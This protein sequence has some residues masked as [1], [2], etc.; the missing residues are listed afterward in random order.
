[1]VRFSPQ[2]IHGQTERTPRDQIAQPS[3]QKNPPKVHNLGRA[4]ALVVEKVAVGPPSERAD[5]SFV[6]RMANDSHV[7]V[8][9]CGV[10]ALALLPHDVL[11]RVLYWLPLKELAV[12]ARVC[13]Y[14]GN[15]IPAAAE[16]KLRVCT[17]EMVPITRLWSCHCCSKWFFRGAYCSCC[18][19][20]SACC[21]QVANA[22][23]LPPPR[24]ETLYWGGV[25]YHRGLRTALCLR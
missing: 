19:Q 24:R 10:G 20:C 1:M 21:G 15:V 18:G 14:L 5:R 4:P 17:H 13:R 7:M 25:S 22:Q 23:A 9:D 3:R 2:R 6:E 11:L 16:Y 12:V 8:S